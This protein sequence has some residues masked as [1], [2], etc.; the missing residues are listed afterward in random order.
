MNNFTS[1]FESLAEGKNNGV[2]REHYLPK[3]LYIP[4]PPFYLI[5]LAKMK[6]RNVTGSSASMANLE[7][8]EDVTQKTAGL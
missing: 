7:L 5:S 1:H 6:N 8:D 3:Y 4:F 2:L